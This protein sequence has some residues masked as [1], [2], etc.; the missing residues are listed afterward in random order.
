MLLLPSSANHLLDSRYQ[1]MAVAC[2]LLW[3]L[4]TWFAGIGLFTVFFWLLWLSVTAFLLITFLF[5][6]QNKA[7]LSLALLLCI[8]AFSG[9]IGYFNTTLFHTFPN[10]HAYLDKPQR[11]TFIFEAPNK[12]DNETGKALQWKIKIAT[13]NNNPLKTEIKALLQLSKVQLEQSSF[14]IGG[15]AQAEITLKEA[16]TAG[17]PGGFNYRQFLALDDIQAIARINTDEP[18][19]IKGQDNSLGYI[20]QRSATETREKIVKEFT[21]ALPR[22]EAQLLGSIVLGEH[23]SPIESNLKTNFRNAGLA[24]ILA[25]SGMNVGLVAAFILWVT[26]LIKLPFRLKIALCMLGTAFYAVMTGL[27]PSILRAG[28]ML[29]IALFLTLIRR[30]LSALLVLNI[31]AII[32]SL[33]NPN[34]LQTVSF[35]LSFLS[36]FGLVAMTPPLERWLGFYVGR[37]IA[38]I[39]LVPLIAQIWV[40][41]IQIL[42]FHQLSLTA[43]PANIIAVPIVALLTY[44]GFGLGLMSLLLPSVGQIIL[45][46]L[47]WPLV[48][49]EWTSSSLGV[50]ALAN[51]TIGNTSVWTTLSLYFTLFVIS[52]Q[53]DWV[54]KIKPYTLQL[55]KTAL[56]LG[57]IILLPFSFAKWQDNHETQ[58]KLFANKDWGGANGL[59][60][61]SNGQVVVTITQYGSS[62]LLNLKSDLQNHG[63]QHINTLILSNAPPERER[64]LNTL[65]TLFKTWD[66]QTVY[67]NQVDSDWSNLLA[68]IETLHNIHPLDFSTQDDMVHAVGDDVVRIKQSES[69]LFTL[70]LTRFQKPFLTWFS[71]HRDSVTLNES[72]QIVLSSFSQEP[73]QAYYQEN[74]TGRHL[75]TPNYFSVSTRDNNQVRVESL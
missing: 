34:I 59:L 15:I 2:C 16:P 42:I 72:P 39:I 21:Q 7:L 18:I 26:T 25:A 63:I 32:L 70:S 35:Q 5:T 45:N 4:G 62:S 12:L 64:S 73:V 22:Q 43:L 23:A 54:S 37:T 6:R 31:A 41:P 38:A 11:A 57:L 69:G 60:K 50:G 74:T 53:L 8:F 56:I 68:S 67:Y 1:Q 29:E 13:L 46:W 49:L 51:I 52:L 36:T 55:A 48:L 27:P 75:V 9:L 17:I 40:I 30:E 28:L 66:V 58:F 24:H 71:G 19:I 65:T 10:I 3:L 20:L 47:Y 14:H 33:F 61:L 44:S